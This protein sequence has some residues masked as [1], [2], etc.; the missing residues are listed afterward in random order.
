[1]GFSGDTCETK[2]ACS[3]NCLNSGGNG[4][5]TNTGGGNGGGTTTA[6]GDT[7]TGTDKPDIILGEEG[8]AAELST[9]GAATIDVDLGV[10]VVGLLVMVNTIRGAFV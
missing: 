2:V 3:L 9:G 1:L 4:G 7:K 8:S 10:W 5:N 6:A